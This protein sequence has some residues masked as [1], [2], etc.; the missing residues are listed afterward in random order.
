[1]NPLAKHAEKHTYYR[2]N[3]KVNKVKKYKK[4]IITFHYHK[5]I[6][7]SVYDEFN[8]YAHPFGQPEIRQ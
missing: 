7:E 1:M 3:S 4:R 2:R 5:A 8:R 6:K